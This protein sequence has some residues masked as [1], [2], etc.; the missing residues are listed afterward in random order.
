TGGDQNE[1]Q[2]SE[3]AFKNLIDF[4]TPSS[5]LKGSGPIAL[6]TTRFSTH[7]DLRRAAALLSEFYR[8]QIIDVNELLDT[9]IT[10]AL[11]PDTSGHAEE[12][13]D[14]VALVGLVL[15]HTWTLWRLDGRPPSKSAA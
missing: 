7:Q 8:S 10:A 2:D 1:Q 3:D 15:R 5:L 13:G 6:T 4:A 9:G 12:A 11:Q 14:A